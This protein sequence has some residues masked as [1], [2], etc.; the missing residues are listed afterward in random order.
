M[1]IRKLLIQISPEA[2]SELSESYNIS[3]KIQ[4]SG[5]IIFCKRAQE[6]GLSN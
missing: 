2:N 4:K 1:I 3:E 6:I 5:I